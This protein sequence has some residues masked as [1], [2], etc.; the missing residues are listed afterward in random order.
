MSGAARAESYR[1]TAAG[2][3]CAT[4]LML[5]AP[6]AVADEVS[7]SPSVSSPGL[8]P[9]ALPGITQSLSTVKQ[10]GCRKGSKQSTDRVPW[11]QTFLRPDAVWPLSEGSG[12][13]VAVVG[14]GVDDTSGVL[15]GRLIR[16]PRLYHAGAAADCVGHGTFVAGL[17]AAKRATGVGFAGVAPQAKIL[18]VSVTDQA[19][20]TNADLLAKGI[21]AA[22]SGGA[23]VIDVAVPTTTGS[24]DLAAAVRYAL[25]KGAVVIAPTTADTAVQQSAQV[26]P[27]AYSGV[28]AV[29]SV[30][31]DGTL[32]QK[33]VAGRVD[34]VGPGESVM[35]TGPAGHGYFTASGPSYATAFVAG[36]A[37][38]VLAY[39]PQLAGVQL[40]HR[41]LVTAYHPGAAMPDPDLGYGSVDPVAA[42]SSVLPEEET[43]RQPVVPVPNERLTMP[44][45][46]DDSANAEAYLVA[47]STLGATAMVVAAAVIVPRGRRRGWRPGA[48]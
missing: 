36:A 25:D 20:S 37:A 7:P 2:L 40:V 23:R 11:A 9:S 39:R 33:A 10:D 34:L 26:Y 6:H 13:L 3:L 24:K 30:G 46:T 17:I 21:R 8:A 29:A 28:L 1:V 27:A 38:L 4:L 32:A 14:S 12:V 19:G 5:S 47:G 42:V 16:G 22:V 18:S 44:P 43:D 45:A 35:G 15:G 31:P 41:L 48:R